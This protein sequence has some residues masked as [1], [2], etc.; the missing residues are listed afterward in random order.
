MYSTL[1]T[2]IGHKKYPG[3]QPVCCWPFKSRQLQESNRLDMVMVWPP[4]IDKGGFQLRIDYV[5][6]SKVLFLFSF[7]SQNDQ[8]RKQH[9]CPLRNIREVDF[10][11]AYSC[12]LM[13]MCIFYLSYILLS[14]DGSTGLTQRLSMR[15]RAI[16]K[17]N[18]LC[19]S[20]SF[21]PNSRWFQW[22]TLEPSATACWER[23]QILMGIPVTQSLGRGGV[24]MVV[25]KLLGNVLVVQDVELKQH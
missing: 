21:Y 9:H 11:I 15:A 20:C 14:P 13:L 22:G 23:L 25:R 18:M 3:E 16:S 4:G 17:Y 24:P 19:P 8:A 5:W 7:V 6:F 12:I 2:R 1:L 10:Q